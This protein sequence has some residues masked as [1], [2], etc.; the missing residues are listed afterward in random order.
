MGEDASR[1]AFGPRKLGRNIARMQAKSV[2][3]YDAGPRR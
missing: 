1:G 3:Y 2:T